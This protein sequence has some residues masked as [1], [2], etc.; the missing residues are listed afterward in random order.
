M[1]LELNGLKGQISSR[2]DRQVIV[3][4]LEDP[5]RL[6]SDKVSVVIKDS[7]TTS[8]VL[9]IPNNFSPG[10]FLK[11]YN[12]K[13]FYFV[14]KHLVRASRAKRVWEASSRMLGRGISTP[15]PLFFLEQ[16][17]FGLL[18]KS[19]FASTVI[20]G[21]QT[22][23]SYIASRFSAMSRTEKLT[24]IRA[25]AG[26]VR[27]MHEKGILHGDLKAKNIMIIDDGD[28][29][30]KLYFVDLDSVRIKNE[31]RFK[32]RCRDISRLNSSFLNTA[33]VSRGYRLWFL[34][35]YLGEADR[36]E[37]KNVLDTVMFFSRRKT[38]KSGLNFTREL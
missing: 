26:H 20:L 32:H 17:R 8:A 7:K 33:I 21:G 11:R 13:G 4:H 38:G 1:K 24:L 12:V 5:D 6:F 22:L 27:K 19:Y 30:P 9:F 18:F 34:K 29:D 23:D 10:I 36:P 15:E 16:R 25:V 35:F 3:G 28:S 2:C 37:F 14:L 31:I